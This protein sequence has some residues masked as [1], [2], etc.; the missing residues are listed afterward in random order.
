MSSGSVD[1]P[2]MKV[3]SFIPF[4]SPLA[5]FARIAMSSV[6]FPEIAVS[7][8]ILIV[9]VLVIGRLAVLIY[10]VGIL[11]YG[12]PPKLNELLKLIRK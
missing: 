4:S 3:L 11:M 8:I 5:M 7:V 10:R 12:N 1:T 6:G 9:S 2:L